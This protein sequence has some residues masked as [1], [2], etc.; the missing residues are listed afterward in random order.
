MQRAFI[1]SCTY[2][3]VRA[4]IARTKELT[5]QFDGLLV[6]D[7]LFGVGILDGGVIIGD[8]VALFNL[9]GINTS[10]FLCLVIEMTD[11]PE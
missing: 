10:Y 8:E 1:S 7:A 6:D 4:G 3:K 5:I 9:I 11:V 2:Y